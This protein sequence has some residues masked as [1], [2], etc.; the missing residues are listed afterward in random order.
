MDKRAMSGYWLLVPSKVQAEALPACGEDA[1][2]RKDGI[3]Y[4]M[5]IIPDFYLHWYIRRKVYIYI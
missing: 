1:G 4:V 5:I 2:K 3:E